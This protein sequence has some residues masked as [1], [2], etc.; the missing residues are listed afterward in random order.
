MQDYQC[1]LSNDLQHSLLFT[2]EKGASNWLTAFPI[3]EHGFCINKSS[4]R[5]ALA[6]WYIW[7]VTF[8]SPLRFSGGK[9]FSIEHAFTCSKGRFPILWHNETRDTTGALLIEVCSNVCVEPHLQPLCNE[10]LN[11]ASAL[12]DAARLGIAVDEF[13]GAR[14]GRGYLDVRVFNPYFAVFSRRQ[15]LPSVYK[16]QEND[17]KRQ[18]SAW[19]REV[20]HPTFTPLALSATGGRARRE[21]SVFYKHLASLMADKWDQ[22]YNFTIN[23]LRCILS[24]SHV[25]PFAALEVLGHPNATWDFSIFIVSVSKRHLAL[26]YLQ[27]LNP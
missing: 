24:F 23:W 1:S 14:R 27:C 8:G 16:A 13:W 9:S 19:V 10:D 2:Q 17:K 4:F 25:Q 12:R 22:P 3:Q 11:G 21:A 26:V 15:S 20:E 5:D 18:Y 7:L 6:M